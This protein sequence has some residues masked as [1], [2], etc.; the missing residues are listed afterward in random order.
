MSAGN[1][2]ALADSTS[3]IRSSTSRCSRW[4]TFMMRTGG[5]PS[6]GRGSM[7][8]EEQN[9]GVGEFAGMV[10]DVVGHRAG[11]AGGEEFDVIGDELRR[12]GPEQGEH[13]GEVA[14]LPVRCAP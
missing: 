6:E 10:T 7:K 1:R 2:P 14:R 4:S 3:M 12:A 5:L 13:F 9:S 8:R 11:R